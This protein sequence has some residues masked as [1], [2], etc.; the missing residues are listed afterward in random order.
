MRWSRS[1][2]RHDGNDR[3]APCRNTGRDRNR[4]ARCAAV[5]AADVRALNTVAENGTAPYAFLAVTAL[6]ALVRDA[7]AVLDVGGTAPHVV[8]AD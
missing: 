4:N 5:S 3:S 8:A 1:I 2:C 7:P 6:H